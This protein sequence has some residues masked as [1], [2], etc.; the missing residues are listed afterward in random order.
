MHHRQK[1]VRREA[2]SSG[3]SSNP[4]LLHTGSTSR[5]GLALI[6]KKLKDVEDPS[7]LNHESL[8]CQEMAGFEAIRVSESFILEDGSEWT[9]DYCE[10]CLLLAKALEASEPL[11]SMYDRAFAASPGGGAWHLVIAFDEFTPG[12]LHKPVNLRKSMVLG[13]NFL[14][15]G[16]EAL[17]QELTWMLP[18][19]LRTSQIKKVPGGWS[20]MLKV[21]LRR[22]LYGP[23]GLCSA[24]FVMS[25]KQGGQTITVSLT[26]EL[27]T[28]LSDGDGLRLGLDWK[29]ASSLKPCFKHANVL[30]TGSDIAH[31]QD[32]FV[33]ASCSDSSLFSRL[34]REELD[35]Q[36]GLIRVAAARRHVRGNAERSDNLQKAYGLNFNPNGLLFDDALM[37]DVDIVSAFTYDWVHT[38]LQDGVMNVEI[39]LFLEACTDKLGLQLKTIETYMKGRFSFPKFCRLKSSQI[40]RLFDKHHLGSPDAEKLKCQASE[41]IAM[42]SALRHFVETEIGD[43]PELANERRSFDAACNV[44]D[45]MLLAKRGSLNLAEAA[46]QLRAAVDHLLVVH[47]RCY[48]ED[49]LKPKHHWM[50]DVADSMERDARLAEAVRKW[51]IVD[52]FVV[53]RLHLRIRS[54]LEHIKNTRT[55]EKSVLAAA[56]NDQIR[57]LSDRSTVR[58]LSGQTYRFG[59]A[60]YAKDI[61][62]LALHISVNDIVRRGDECAE[63]CA[64]AVD[65]DGRQFLK[66]ETLELVSHVSA[67][68]NRWRK[69][70]IAI[71]WDVLQCDLVA[72]WYAV[73]NDLIVVQL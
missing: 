54:L 68:S 43:R 6:I 52:A 16:Q 32:G 59:R 71:E 14:E 65:D 70:G 37:R 20:C 2:Q 8:L 66:A 31:R 17:S 42:Y 45:I 36:I 63:V 33:E 58:G 62:V 30:K 21:F 23:H 56:T 29:G 38:M 19:V 12:S 27:W 48:G 7:A 55:L 60:L 24:G 5:N 44:L 46:V 26:A 4:N 13:F 28:L 61:S 53:E 69:T 67:H 10:P 73:D 72:A 41:L 1:R 64:C 25:T 18:I 34:S 49:H 47:K 51:T 57:R 22:L 11:Q 50:Y 15:L 3:Q 35:E 9:W 39:L 40:W